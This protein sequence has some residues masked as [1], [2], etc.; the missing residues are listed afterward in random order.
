MLHIGAPFIVGAIVGR[1]DDHRIVV[2]LQI[3]QQVNQI[4]HH[5][6]HTTD[7]GGMALGHL[8]RKTGIVR[9][10]IS[11]LILL[12]LGVKSRIGGLSG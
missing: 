11:I 5:I 7:H 1:E 4:R 12:R 10:N 9:I 6:I 3:L 2:Y 8:I